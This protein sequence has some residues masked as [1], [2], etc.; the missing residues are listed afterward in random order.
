MAFES[1]SVSGSGR[2][3]IS[4]GVGIPKS[5]PSNLAGT[6]SPLFVVAFLPGHLSP[7]HW[8]EDLPALMLAVALC[9]FWLS[10]PKTFSVGTHPCHSAKCFLLSCFGAFLNPRS[11]WKPS[12]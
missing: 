5:L 10:L 9:S 3:Q 12:L 1:E 4:D 11:P 7:V 8:L 6:F 2:E